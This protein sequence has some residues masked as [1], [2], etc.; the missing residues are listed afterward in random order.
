M[1][2]FIRKDADIL[3]YTSPEVVGL[4]VRLVEVNSRLAFSNCVIRDLVDPPPEHHERLAQNVV[5][6]RGVGA[7]REVASHGLDDLVH[8]GLEAIGFGHGPHT[9][10][11]PDARQFFQV[12]SYPSP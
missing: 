6:G 10:L 9:W 7:A 1:S 8:D 5:G 3:G 11:C 4:E 2:Y 12:N